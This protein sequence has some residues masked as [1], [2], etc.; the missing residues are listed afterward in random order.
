MGHHDFRDR[1][2]SLQIRKCESSNSAA[3]EEKEHFGAVAPEISIDGIMTYYVPTQQGETQQRESMVARVPG[4]G[5]MQL[6][7]ALRR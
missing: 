7:S 5:A 2:R 4:K 1:Y 3:V 6:G